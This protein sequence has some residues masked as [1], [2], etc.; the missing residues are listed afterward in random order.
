VLSTQTNP[1]DS[2]L[3]NLLT[4][5]TCTCVRQMPIQ[6]QPQP[7][8]DPSSFQQIHSLFT[9]LQSLYREVLHPARSNSSTASSA[10]PSYHGSI[11]GAFQRSKEPIS[12]DLC[13]S[14]RS[15][16]PKLLHLAWFTVTHLHHRIQ[17]LYIQYISES[18][19]S[20]SD[21]LRSNRL[22]HTLLSETHISASSATVNADRH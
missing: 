12:R 22:L 14:E 21:L 17:A 5:H 4:L 7:P 13:V 15:G 3:S 11:C 8:F 19:M 9:R 2:P 20:L 16:R 18:N 6:P 10:A 1:S